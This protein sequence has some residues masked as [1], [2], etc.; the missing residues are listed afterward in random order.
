ML[1]SEHMKQLKEVRC[2]T[3]ILM[4][5]EVK[6]V[7]MWNSPVETKEI[8]SKIIINTNLKDEIEC[9]IKQN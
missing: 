1:H 4:D 2:S 6:A 8:R 9:Q 7:P 5:A 3:A